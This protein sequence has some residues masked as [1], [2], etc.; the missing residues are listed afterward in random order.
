MLLN[1][2]QGW[3]VQVCL[4]SIRIGMLFILTPI[5][6]NMRG[7]TTARVLLVLALSVALAA[8][9]APAPRGLDLEYGPLLAAG[10]AEVVTGGVLAFGLFAAFS[11]FSVAG[12]ILDIQSG[13]SIGSVYDPVTGGGAP[14]FTTV[15]NLAAVALF[16]ALDG[17][18]ETVNAVQDGRAAVDRARR[19]ATRERRTTSRE[20]GNTAHER[21]LF[22][23]FHFNPVPPND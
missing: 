1:I 15:L 13:F 10:A 7:V 5:F 22:D 4:A 16:F 2:D 9:L 20:K 19:V 12:K 14:V 8:N 17:H 21:Q 3:L 11:A 6:S 18:L 23:Q